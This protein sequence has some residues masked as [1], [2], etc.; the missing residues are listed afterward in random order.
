MEGGPQTTPTVSMTG[1]SAGGR[2]E[3]GRVGKRTGGKAAIGKSG[4]KTATPN[5]P[6]TAISPQSSEYG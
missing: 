3:G 2:G 4:N 1:G 5:P 6:L